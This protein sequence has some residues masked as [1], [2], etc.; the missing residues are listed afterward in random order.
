MSDGRISSEQ[1]GDI[2]NTLV[3]ISRETA[4]GVGISVFIDSVLPSLGMV[5]TIEAGVSHYTPPPPGGTGLVD[6]F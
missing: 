3:G 5:L 1:C 4:P 2:T 6:Q